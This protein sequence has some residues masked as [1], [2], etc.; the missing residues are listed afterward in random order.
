[1][2]R[3]RSYRQLAAVVVPVG[4]RLKLKCWYRSEICDYSFDLKPV[5]GVITTTDKTAARAPPSSTHTTA[6]G[7]T[8]RAMST[9]N[10]LR[11]CARDDLRYLG[12][13]ENL[14]RRPPRKC[15]LASSRHERRHHHIFKLLCIS[16][17]DVVTK[18][19]LLHL[20]I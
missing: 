17:V 8:S 5:E 14:G 2:Y 18:E 1:M 4:L 10:V 13:P 11:S 16:F 20:K 6:R 3:Y 15:Q 19:S 7:P 9:F 12:I